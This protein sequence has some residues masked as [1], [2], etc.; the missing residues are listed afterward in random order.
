MGGLLI[1]QHK[2]A[3]GRDS[4]IASRRGVLAPL[5]PLPLQC[6]TRPCIPA[7]KLRRSSRGSARVTLSGT[8][9]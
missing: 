4:T 6:I 7:S 3:A 1:A 5:T 9:A 8:S 2:L